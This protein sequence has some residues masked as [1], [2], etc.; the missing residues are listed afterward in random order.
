MQSISH[1]MVDIGCPGERRNW[2]SELYSLIAELHSSIS[3]L[4][5]LV[6]STSGRNL[7]GIVSQF[8]MK[9]FIVRHHGSSH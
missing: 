8:I 2:I 3:E 7:P 9:D 1:S 6:C 4:H 5:I